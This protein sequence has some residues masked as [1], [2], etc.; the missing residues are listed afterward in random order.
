MDDTVRINASREA[1][2]CISLL[3]CH[4]LNLLAEKNLLM[5]NS[6]NTKNIFYWNARHNDEC[7]VD[8]YDNYSSKYYDASITMD[9]KSFLQDFILKDKHEEKSLLDIINENKNFIKN[10]KYDYNGIKNI[11][12]PIWAGMISFGFQLKKERMN[13][14]TIKI[15]NLI[16]KLAEDIKLLNDF[17]K[18][19]Q[20]KELLDSLIT[21][22]KKLEIKALDV[23][24]L[25]DNRITEKD[26]LPYLK[27][28]N[29]ENLDECV[30]PPKLNK[31]LTAQYEDFYSKLVKTFLAEN[32]GGDH[33]QKMY[34]FRKKNLNKINIYAKTQ[35]IEYAKL[36]INTIR[37]QPRLGQLLYGLCNLQDSFDY[38]YKLANDIYAVD[39]DK[40]RIGFDEILLYK[41]FQ[42]IIVFN[43]NPRQIQKLSILNSLS[44]N[45]TYMTA[46]SQIKT[47]LPNLIDLF[48]YRYKKLAKNM[49]V[50]Y[51]IVPMIDS[52]IK[53][54][55]EYIDMINQ[56]K[57][58]LEEQNDLMIKYNSQIDIIPFFNNVLL[59]SYFTFDSKFREIYKLLTNTD[60]VDIPT[61]T[62]ELV[63]NIR[64]GAFTNEYTKNKYYSKYLKYKKKYLTISTK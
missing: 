39:L 61:E 48:N 38:A 27:K 51:D 59:D 10:D 49:N 32:E 16:D 26:I 25:L 18:S 58:I 15:N 8:L 11:I 5:Y 7:W 19:A 14:I 50:N 28:M 44:F 20:K 13:K 23:D 42:K 22:V 24:Y 30:I 9:I 43:Q 37:G 64:G 56:Q 17:D 12:C 63:Y 62:N 36:I 53:N 54:I 60:F 52:N 47:E 46:L 3:D 40:L 34:D 31:Y 35:T 6:T 45:F 55:E 1:D 41:Y 21:S 2:G 29:T 57:K 33:F 4:N